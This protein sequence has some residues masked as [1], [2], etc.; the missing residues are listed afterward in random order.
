MRRQILLKVSGLAMLAATTACGTADPGQS[1]GR[2]ALEIHVQDELQGAP[3]NIT[4]YEKTNGQSAEL[5]GV[6]GYTLFFAATVEYPEGYRTECLKQHQGMEGFSIGMRCSQD[7][8]FNDTA[9]RPDYAGGS[10]QL[11]G[12]T[13]FSLTENGWMAERTQV[14]VAD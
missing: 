9:F 12:T 5:N 10:V 7:F 4:S 2:A 14:S 1:E 11:N 6:Q 3:F 8:Q 13:S